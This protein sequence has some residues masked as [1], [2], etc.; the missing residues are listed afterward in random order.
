MYTI[1]Y[2]LYTNSH[3]TSWARY[4]EREGPAPCIKSHLVYK[5][6]PIPNIYDSGENWEV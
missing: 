6:L 4:L 3:P 1:Y 2:I 5:V